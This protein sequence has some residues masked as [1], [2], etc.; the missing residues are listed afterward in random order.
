MRSKKKMLSKMRRPPPMENQ[1]VRPLGVWVMVECRGS[2]VIGRGS[3]VIGRGSRVIGRGSKV[4]VEGRKSRVKN[5]RSRVKSRWL[6]VEIQES[7][8]GNINILLQ[9][10][11]FYYIFVIFVVKILKVLLITNFI[12]VSTEHALGHN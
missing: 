6:K 8:M 3:R 4:E 9:V 5:R 1:M 7:K 10:I 2:R 12:T 11:H